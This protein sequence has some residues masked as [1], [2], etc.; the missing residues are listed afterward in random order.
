MSAAAPIAVRGRRNGEKR[1][2]PDHASSHRKIRSGLI[3]RHSSMTRRALYM[4][5][6][7][8]QLVRSSMRT[9]SQ[10]ALR[11]QA[12]QRALDGVERHRA[13]HR[14]LRHRER[15]DVERLRARQHH[16]VVVRL[17]AVAVDERDVAGRRAAP[18]PTILFEVDVPLVTK[19]TWSAP[20]ARAAML[21]RALDVAGRL[22]QAVEAA[23]GGAALGEE[24]VDAV[25][26]AH[27]ADPVGLE[28]RLA[29]RDRQ[30][31]E[32]A[33]RAPRVFLQVVEERRFVA[34]GDAFE[35]RRD[36]ISSGSSTA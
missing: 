35:D 16:A 27:V 10:P 6:S 14:V 28:H 32:G 3:A 11:P 34:V 9:R 2:K 24:Q 20:K 23:G 17:V 4:C 33:D 13:V 22:E 12:E 29:A 21:L 30:G 36:A 19:N 31:V 25:E 8:V 15:L 5:P 7:K 26:L 18:A 1:A